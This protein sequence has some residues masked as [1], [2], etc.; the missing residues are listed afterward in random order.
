MKGTTHVLFVT[1]MSGSMHHLAA[2]VR[3]GFAEYVD[4]LRREN[5]GDRFRLTV[6]VFNTKAQTL[7][8]CVPLSQAPDMT[9]AYQPIGGTALRDALG[10]ALSRKLD[11]GDDDRVLCV[12]QTDGWENASVDYSEEQVRDLLAERE[13]SGRWTFVYL[14]AGPDTWQ[15][16]ESLGIR[17]TAYVNTEHSK[18]GTIS[19][20][21]NLS[22]AT[23]SFARGAS[24]D[25][26]VAMITDNSKTT[27]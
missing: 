22:T 1:D 15:Q 6:I 18:E 24:A 23:R 21:S 25:E 3:R 13:A 20:Y 12:I 27:P 2:A 17:R 14:G 11:L 8:A 9:K 26:T 16:A 4:A 5:G 19:M 7:C 10:G